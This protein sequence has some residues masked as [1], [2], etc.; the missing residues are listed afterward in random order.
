MSN[1][2]STLERVLWRLRSLSVAALLALVVVGSATAAWAG[3][4]PAKNYRIATVPYYCVSAPTGKRCVN[5]MVYYPN[6]ARAK[7][8][9]PAY[10][11]PADFPLLGPVKQMFILANLDRKQYGLPPIAG[12]TSAL[13][14]DA[15]VRGV[16]AGTEPSPSDPAHVTAWTANSAA[17]YRNAPMAYEAWMWDDGLGSGNFECTTAHPAGCWGHRHN[18]LWRFGATAVTAMGAAAGLG[19]NHG[20]AYAIILVRG[21]AS[22]KPT[23]AYTWKQAV[24]AGAGTHTYNPGTP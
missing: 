16:Q 20:R 13:N 14:R 4:D 22:Y 23:Y 7:V 3:S 2:R 10:K 24:A 12:L 15:L 1:L 5:A 8:G 6:R 11:L 21:D 17:G 9:L 19:P 18:I